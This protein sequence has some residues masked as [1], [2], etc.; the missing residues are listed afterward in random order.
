[1][2]ILT[3]LRRVES[4]NQ[5]ECSHGS[6]SASKARSAAAHTFDAVGAQGG[7]ER[8]AADQV[9]DVRLRLGE[10]EAHLVRVERLREQDRY[11]LGGGMRRAPAGRQNHVAAQVVVGDEFLGAGVEPVERQ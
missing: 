8:A 9:V 3:G 4:A 2:G 11:Q 5:Q 10:G 6:A 1:M 7:V